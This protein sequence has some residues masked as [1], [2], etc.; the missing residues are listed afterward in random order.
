[1]RSFGRAAAWAALVASVAGA[2]AVAVPPLVGLT[3]PVTTRAVPPPV[4]APPA[5]LTA[6]ASCDGFMSTA[7]SLAWEAVDGADAYELQRRGTGD[8]A[9]RTVGTYGADVTAVRDPELGIDTTYRYRVRAT[10]GPEVG[11]WSR[12]AEARTPLLCLL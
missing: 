2:I 8:A 3:R 9:F 7:A 1:V 12:Q 4:L 5:D 6:T 11:A 10:D